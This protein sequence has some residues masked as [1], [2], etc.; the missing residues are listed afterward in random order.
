MLQSHSAPPKANQRLQLRFS[1]GIAAW[2]PGLSILCNISTSLE[3][4]HEPV[5]CLSMLLPQGKRS[6]KQRG[7]HQQQQLAW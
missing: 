2:W 6:G 4:A 7:Q 3:C 1:A 5:S